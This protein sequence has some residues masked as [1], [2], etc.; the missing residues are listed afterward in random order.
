M[1]TGIKGSV[2][3]TKKELEGFADAA[4][5]VSAQQATEMRNCMK[6]YIDK[7]LAAML[8]GYITDSPQTYEIK[9]DGYY[10]VTEEFHKVIAYL[11]SQAEQPSYTY[12]VARGAS[13][14]QAK[15]SH[16]IG[17]A[18]QNQLVQGA[19]GWSSQYGSEYKITRKGLAYVLS[20]GLVK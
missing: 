1:G 18:A 9:T 15:A 3:L 4:S 5:A 20:K 11:A 6:P 17:I 7:I 14:N 16:Y 2:T 13:I 10:F 12:Q 8:S 19:G